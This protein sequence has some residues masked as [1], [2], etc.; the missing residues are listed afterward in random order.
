MTNENLKAAVLNGSALY[1]DDFNSVRI[2]EWFAQERRG[3]YDIADNAEYAYAYHALNRFHGFRLLEGRYRR[4]L[5]LGC[6]RGDEILPIADRLD[7]IIA[8]EP[9]EPW[10]SSK[11]GNTPARYMAPQESGDI[12]LK[13]LSVDLVTC[14]GV[15]HHIPNVT[16]V[17]SEI[18]RVM[19]PGAVFLLREPSSSMG[20]WRFPRP[21]MT[22]NERGISRHWVIATA[23]GLG[24]EVVR[25]AHC[26]FG[27]I[28]KLLAPFKIN[29]HSSMPIVA[30]DWVVSSLFGWNNRYWR[31]RL[32]DKFAPGSVFYVLRKPY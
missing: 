23:S 31:R 26:D 17:M 8:I 6:A 20:D 1:G 2:A 25:A 16:H 27:P 14:F 24:L 28:A 21:G 13:D 18:V 10:W 7:E 15:L 4:C 29:P 5:A 19:R 3:Y 12:A 32:T 30:V 11:I 9:A 22:K